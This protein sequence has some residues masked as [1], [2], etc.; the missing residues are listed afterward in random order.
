MG[1]QFNMYQDSVYAGHH[2]RCWW[3]ARSPSHGSCQGRG[4]WTNNYTQLTEH[5]CVKDNQVGQRNKW[6]TAKNQERKYSMDMATSEMPFDARVA[7]LTNEGKG[8]KPVHRMEAWDSFLLYMG[9]LFSNIFS[10]SNLVKKSN[11]QC[12]LWIDSRYSSVFP[13]M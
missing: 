4:V 12:W 1:L 13:K 9:R 5:K 6:L 8:C 11:A 7:V 10:H 2:R 3:G